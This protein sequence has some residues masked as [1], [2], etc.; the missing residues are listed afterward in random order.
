MEELFLIVRIPGYV[1]RT[2]SPASQQHYVKPFPHDLRALDG[3]S[4][5]RAASR[6]VY[7]PRAVAIECR[8]VPKDCLARPHAPVD[9]LYLIDNARLTKTTKAS[10]LPTIQ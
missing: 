9:G 8:V 7:G 6:I 3:Y 10:R 5:F 4:G 1:R 2:T